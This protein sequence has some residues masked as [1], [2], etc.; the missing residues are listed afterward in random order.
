[1]TPQVSLS[2]SSHT[3]FPVVTSLRHEPFEFTSCVASIFIVTEHGYR[4]FKPQPQVRFCQ[5]R[6]T[7]PRSP[8]CYAA[9]E[10]VDST[11]QAPCATTLP[12]LL[13]PLPSRRRSRAYRW[14][15]TSS[16]CSC[17]CVCSLPA[18]NKSGTNPNHVLQSSS[19]RRTSA[20]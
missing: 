2:A 8:N 12:L 4:T 1:V 14:Q 3:Q 5:C 13:R 17:V 20:R 7:F 18:A 6:C 11:L 10:D 9:G 19:V 15:P 16:V